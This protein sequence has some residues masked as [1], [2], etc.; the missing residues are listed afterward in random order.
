[1]AA[2]APFDV[3]TMSKAEILRRIVA[4]KLTTAAQ[5]IFAVVQRTV[6]GYEEEASGLRQEIDR[7]RRLLELLAQPVI[8]LKRTGLDLLRWFS[9][10]S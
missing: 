10:H 5:E 7:Q 8:K 3:G 2:E 1:M 4:D 9:E 6:A